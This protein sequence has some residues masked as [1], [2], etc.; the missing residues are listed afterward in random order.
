MVIYEVEISKTE[1]N[2]LASWN[3]LRDKINNYFAVD[4][5]QIGSRVTLP[6]V[7]KSTC[8]VDGVEHFIEKNI[9]TIDNFE[10]NFNYQFKNDVLNKDECNKS[11]S[12][13]VWN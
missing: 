2:T 12:L 1:Y 8:V 10:L 11:I 3:Y 5:S 6:H 9:D 7:I 4:F 13:Q